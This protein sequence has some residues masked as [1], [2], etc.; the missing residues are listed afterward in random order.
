VGVSQ[1]CRAAVMAHPRL[2]R[3]HFRSS[4]FFR[5]PD[6]DPRD[7][8]SRADKNRINS[9]FLSF[10]LPPP[11]LETRTRIRGRQK[12]ATRALT[13]TS[14]SIQDG[15]RNLRAGFHRSRYGAMFQ[16]RKLAWAFCTRSRISTKTLRVFVAHNAR[17][18]YSGAGPASARR[19]LTQFLI[20]HS[21][22][23]VRW[24]VETVF[25]E[26]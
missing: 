8:V 5:R 10:F 13:S 19:M 23:K 2:V 25:L 11:P 14:R 21:R 24:M 3:M 7:V 12:T 18:I 9:V 1:R 15:G 6:R 20:A 22:I 16:I 4:M 26:C 17:L